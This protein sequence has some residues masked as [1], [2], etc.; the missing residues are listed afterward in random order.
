M[1]ELRSYVEQRDKAKAI[2]PE[3]CDHRVRVEA[4]LRELARQFDEWEVEAIRAAISSIADSSA[5]AADGPFPAVPVPNS[6]MQGERRVAGCPFKLP[7]SRPLRNCIDNTVRLLEQDRILTI[8]LI[9]AVEALKE[10]EALFL[11]KI[12][13]DN[14]N[15]NRD[16]FLPADTNVNTLITVVWRLSRHNFFDPDFLADI[17]DL[18]TNLKSTLLSAIAV[19]N[20]TDL[21]VEGILCR[22]E[23]S[24]M[25][26][27]YAD[28]MRKW[29][30]MRR[31]MIKYL[32]EPENQD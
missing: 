14:F 6:G 11:D 3:W 21:A 29:H 17:V 24:H 13:F 30:N 19:R 4:E 2:L 16:I 8:D 9:E 26:R 10:K 31:L 22:C 12:D 1:E 20:I 15:E 23:V 18:L 28:D 7:C 25:L 5:D 32:G 27:T